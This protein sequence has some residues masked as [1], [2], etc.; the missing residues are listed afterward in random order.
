[1]RSADWA[2]AI[3]LLCPCDDLKYS[4]KDVSSHIRRRQLVTHVANGFC[5]ALATLIDRDDDVPESPQSF[6]INGSQLEMFVVSSVHHSHSG[7]K[8][9]VFLASIARESEA[10]CLA[11]MLEQTW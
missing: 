10:V 1:M 7:R 8:H 11:P 3:R 9:I 2:A 6:V 5:S 4:R